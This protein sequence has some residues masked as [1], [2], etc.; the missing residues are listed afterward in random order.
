MILVTGATG[1]VGSELVDTL[2]ER[3]AEN[4]RA[5]ADPERASLPEG[6]DVGT[7]DLSAPAGL[8]AALTDVRQAFLLGAFATPELLEALRSAGVE[9]VVLLTSRCVI[10]GRPD[11]AITRMWLDAEAVVRDWRIPSTVLHPSSFDSNALRWLPQLRRGDVVRAPWPQVPI[12]AIDP[13]DIASGRRGGA[14]RIRPGRTAITLS[15]PQPSHR[16]TRSRR[17]PRCSTDRCATSRSPTRRRVP[18]CTPTHPNRSST[19]SSGSTRTASSTTPVS[20]IPSTVSRAD[21]RVPSRN[22]PKP[23]RRRFRSRGTD[24]WMW[25]PEIARAITRRWISEVPSKI[26]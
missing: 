20:S 24:Y 14:H 22:G 19:R 10:G 11:N 2:L 26:V 18:N 6:V 4:A 3:G 16:A 8:T 21:R 17:S 12:A 5:G 23:T 15:G 7:G 25:T 1:N 13:A 9:H